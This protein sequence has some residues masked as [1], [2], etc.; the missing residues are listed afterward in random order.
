MSKT[1]TKPNAFVCVKWR[2]LMT[3]EVVT[4]SVTVLNHDSERMLQ[5]H[6]DDNTS[7]RSF[8]DVF[9]YHRGPKRITV[10][11]I[12]LASSHFTGDAGQAKTRI[13][14]S[15]RMVKAMVFD[16]NLSEFDPTLPGER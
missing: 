15:M 10:H 13:I 1:D 8:V 5:D 7:E 6:C 11:S 3:G 2:A 9:A 12:G 4:F 14:H 16:L